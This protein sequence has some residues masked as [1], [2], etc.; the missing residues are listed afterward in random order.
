MAKQLAQ[1]VAQLQVQVARLE[2]LAVLRPDNDPSV[3]EWGLP[4]DHDTVH[5]RE[6]GPDARHR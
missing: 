1:L 2:R 5:P 6:G 4:F 3:D